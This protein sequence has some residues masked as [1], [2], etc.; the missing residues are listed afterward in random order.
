MSAPRAHYV[1]DLQTGH[2]KVPQHFTQNPSMDVWVNNQH[3]AY[4][5]SLLSDECIAILNNVVF[6]WLLKYLGI[7]MPRSPRYH[8]LGPHHVYLSPQASLATK[9]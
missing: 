2:C 1:H 7:H 5:N 8:V 9:Y 3:I 4:Q 6:V